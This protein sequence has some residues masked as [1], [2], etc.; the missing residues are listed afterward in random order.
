MPSLY[1][2][3]EIDTECQAIQQQSTMHWFHQGNVSDF[4]A[5]L[6]ETYWGDKGERSGL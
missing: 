3:S 5:Q 1:E 4:S 6:I 2:P